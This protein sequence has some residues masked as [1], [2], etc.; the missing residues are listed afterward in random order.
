VSSNEVHA[1][2]GKVGR[3]QRLETLRTKATKV[4]A[5]RDQLTSELDEKERDLESLSSRLAILA[6]VSELYLMLLDR[7]VKGQV[8]V[9]DEVV[10]HGFQ[11]IFFDQNIR[12]ETEL[13][14]KYNKVSADFFVCDGDPNKGGTRGDPLESYGG[15]PATI[16]SLTLRLLTILRL[17]R[18]K[19][20]L[21]DETLSAVSDEYVEN[22]SLFLKG[23]ADT[24]GLDIFLVTQK[25]SYVDYAPTAY[26]ADTKI[27]GGRSHLTLRRARGSKNENQV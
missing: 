2:T 8:K 23:L 1:L 17:K 14:S 4:K 11:T 22:T 16:A 19:F 3:R 15:G 26:Q 27:E 7:M 10:T 12:F 25:H 24:M 5:L 20:L 13:S 18:R 9:I 21:L 6:N